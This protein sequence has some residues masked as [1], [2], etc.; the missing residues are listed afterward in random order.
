MEFGDKRSALEIVG[1]V[2]ANRRI[3]LV[4]LYDKLGK[5]FVR[6]AN[7][8]ASNTIPPNMG[9]RELL[10]AGGFVA[11]NPI[12]H[13]GEILGS[14]LLKGG[15]EDLSAR[16]RSYVL[17]AVAMIVV[18]V[19]IAIYVAMGLQRRIFDPIA[20]VVSVMAGIADRKDYSVRIENE[21]KDEVGRLIQ[22]FNDMLSEV[23]VRDDALQGAL[24]QA[25]AAIEAKS[26]FLAKMSHEIRTPMNGVL[27]M[28]EI[29]QG[30]E[31]DDLQAQCADTIELSAKNLLEIVN[32][33]LDF[34]KAEAGKLK[35]YME[36]FE[37]E[38]MLGE[39]AAVLAP[40][41][42]NKS[43]E[44]SS[45]CSP[46]IPLRVN[47]DP[48]R[49]RQVLL[50]LMGNAIK[51]TEKGGVGL[52]VQGQGRSD[53]RITLRFEVRD[54]GVGIPAE[55]QELIFQSFMQVDG[56]RTRK[57][58]GT[59]LGLT[60]S[61]QLVELMGGTLSV[62]STPGSGSTFSFVIK[63][64]IVAEAR[65]LSELDGKRLLLATSDESSA[66][67][68]SK[69]LA[70]HGIEVLLAGNATEAAKVLSED[71]KLDFIVADVVLP[72]SSGWDIAVRVRGLPGSHPSVYLLGDATHPIPSVK[73]AERGVTGAVLRP[74]M[75]N[76]LLNLLVQ[77]TKNERGSRTRRGKRFAGRWTPNILLVEDNEVNALVASH[78]L[79][80]IG[81]MFKIASDGEEAVQMATGGEFDL[82]LMDVQLPVFDGLEATRRIRAHEDPRVRESVI[83]AMTAN[84]M[85]SE[86]DACLEA[87]MNDYLSKPMTQADLANMI[88]KWLGN[89]VA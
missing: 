2:S 14:I 39:V 15:D 48:G 82:V 4:V 21:G 7:P 35:L 55:Q 42:A 65:K 80:N 5:E 44:I 87:G 72:P 61:R 1:A 43:L 57:Q 58:G 68:L 84:A 26:L 76:N 64:E 6:Y 47:G 63:L 53:G 50:N 56:G 67:R 37:L 25:N 89:A 41:A 69:T 85:S 36:S 23:Q 31:L 83:V 38:S 60:I 8:A 62:E 51:F 11:E 40:S 24:K 54:S 71:D 20:Q 66:N 52:E 79:T 22:T 45:W 3:D 59:G 34:S 27:G 75:G 78:F 46:D 33:L 73:A 28:T 86:R 81:C 77:D 10:Q 17:V 29:L 19:L 88:S 9:R 70:Y 49:L 30:T 32:D 18:A 13:D 12:S 16:T 74:F